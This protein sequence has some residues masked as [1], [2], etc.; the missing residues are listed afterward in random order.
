MYT[1]DEPFMRKFCK[2]T[3]GS[4]GEPLQDPERRDFGFKAPDAKKKLRTMRIFADRK[5]RK[6]AGEKALTLTKAN[7]F[8]EDKVDNQTKSNETINLNETQLL[9]LKELKRQAKKGD[10]QEPTLLFKTRELFCSQTFL[11]VT[12][13]N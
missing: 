2:Q 9:E 5:K 7:V 6:A 3:C 12:P 11:F 8:E 13:E 1:C 4:C 10:I